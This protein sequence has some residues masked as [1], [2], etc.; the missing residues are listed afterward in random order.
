MNRSLLALLF[1]VAVVSPG[2]AQPH[3]IAVDSS[4]TLYE[5]NVAT[6]AKTQIATVSANAGTPGGLAVGAGNVVY[7][8]STSNDS[9]FTLNVA[10]G[11][12]T[13]VGAYG[14][15]AIVMH[16]LEYVPETSTLFGV[17]SHNNGLY[18]INTTTG[19]ATLIGTSGLTSFTNLGWSSATDV[20]YATNSGTDSLYTMNLATGAA[21]LVG[22]LTG[23]TNPNGLAFDFNNSIMFMVDNNTDTFYSLNLATGAATAI[24]STGTGNLLGLAYTSGPVPVELLD[25]G[26]E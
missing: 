3:V 5:I 12:A 1:V 25:F 20:M 17:S 11:S 15:S 18:N 21:T 6:G 2:L 4:R 23:P 13:L 7:L 19:A 10:S 8:T 16:G 22:P 26:V 14:D 24:G 9:L